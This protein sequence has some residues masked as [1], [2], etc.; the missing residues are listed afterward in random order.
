[1]KEIKTAIPLKKRAFN[2]NEVQDAQ[3]MI[4]MGLQG[5]QKLQ[6]PIADHK[7]DNFSQN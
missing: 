2:R 4:A 1:M 5:K 7:Q 3:S 6:L